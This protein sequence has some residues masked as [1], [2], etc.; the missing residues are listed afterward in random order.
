MA[1]ALLLLGCQSISTPPGE[2]RVDPDLRIHQLRTL[3]EVAPDHISARNPKEVQEQV[4]SKAAIRAQAEAL[5]FHYPRHVPTL[6]FTAVLAYEAGEPREAEQRLDDLLALEPSHPEAAVLRSRIALEDGNTPFATRL[7]TDQIRMRP[8]HAGLREAA[9]AAY[10]VAGDIPAAVEALDGAE[11][12]GAPTW[13]VA[14]HRGV[15]AEANG[16]E[17]G[18]RTH[19]ETA[20]A[21]KPG[22]DLPRQ[23]LEGLGVVEPAKELGSVD[24]SYPPAAP[25]LPR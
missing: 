7:L 16:D 5:L 13:R 1:A 9:A 24:P 17:S 11:R 23:R 14:Y 18:A 3:W 6:L 8:D 22:W 4:P 19:Y 2:A 21:G 12:L 10:Y 25:P 15:L 20:L